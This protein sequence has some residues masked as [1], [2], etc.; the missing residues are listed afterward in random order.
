M[1]YDADL[2]SM[3]HYVQQH[4]GELAKRL[5]E[6]FM[7]DM[8][9]SIVLENGFRIKGEYVEEIKKAYKDP[10]SMYA[11]LVDINPERRRVTAIKRTR[12]CTGFGLKEAK[13]V[14]DELLKR[15]IL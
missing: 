3:L 5:L 10:R 6:R 14:V 9:G 1:A 7:P 8:D 2:V 12:E 11:D 15:N 4:D 13:D